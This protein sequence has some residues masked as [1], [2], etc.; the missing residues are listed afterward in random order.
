MKP[1]QRY[2]V[3]NIAT[4]ALVGIFDKHRA[5]RRPLKFNGAKVAVLNDDG[6][7]VDTLTVR[8]SSSKEYLDIYHNTNVAYKDVSVNINTSEDIDADFLSCTYNQEVV[9]SILP[10]KE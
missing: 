3:V 2:A 6:D 8:L 5:D 4:N 7:V 10:V 9:K 1:F